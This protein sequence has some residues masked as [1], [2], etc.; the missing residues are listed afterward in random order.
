MAPVYKVFLGAVIITTLAS[1]NKKEDPD[2]PPP[3]AVQ[4]KFVKEGELTFLLSDG[5]PVVKINIELAETEAEQQQGLMN[6]PFMGNDQ[7]MLFI[8]DADEIRG[9]WM[10]NTIIPLDIL[11]VNSAMEIVHIAENTQPFSDRSIPSVKPAK[12]VVEVNAGF[13][14]Q[15]G[16]TAGNRIEYNRI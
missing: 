2:E 5:R 8:F 16:I 1:C 12:Y 10:H 15:Y 7:G 6:R 3:V 11:Y 9:F 14:A 13:C 4:P